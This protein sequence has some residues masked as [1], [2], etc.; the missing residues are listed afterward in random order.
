MS[1]DEKVC[2][3]NK[4]RQGIRVLEWGDGRWDCNFKLNNQYSWKVMLRQST[5]GG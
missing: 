3:K 1:D 4:A 2:E 5:E